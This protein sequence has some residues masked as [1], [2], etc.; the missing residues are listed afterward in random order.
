MSRTRARKK[1]TDQSRS[2]TGVFQGGLML[3]LDVKVEWWVSE[4]AA[5]RMGITD[6]EVLA[7]VKAGEIVGEQLPAVHMGGGWARDPMVWWVNAESCMAYVRKRSATAHLTSE[8]HDA[9]T[10]DDDGNYDYA[11]EP[12]VKYGLLDAADVAAL[13]KRWASG[14]A[15]G[16]IR[17]P[18]DVLE[19]D[20]P[21]LLKEAA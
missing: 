1:R 17:V 6:H 7:L 20:P 12:I 14:I 9:R 3:G 2:H 21:A 8:R 5:L 4:Q 15:S 16:R 13:N 19:V 11:P 18:L 10:T